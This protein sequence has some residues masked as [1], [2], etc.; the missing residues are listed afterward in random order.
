MVPL[1]EYDNLGQSDP[2]SDNCN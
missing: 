2:A 1:L